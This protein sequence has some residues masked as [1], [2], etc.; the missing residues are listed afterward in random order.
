[1][2]KEASRIKITVLKRF[3]TEEAFKD[4]PVKA[5]RALD[6]KIS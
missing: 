2:E 1:L 6:Q 5:A 4:P 3:G